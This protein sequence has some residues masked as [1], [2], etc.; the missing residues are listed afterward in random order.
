[1]H[2]LTDGDRVWLALSWTALC[3]LA[4]IAVAWA[5]TGITHGTLPL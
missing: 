4:A 1:M 5:G 2:N 3:L